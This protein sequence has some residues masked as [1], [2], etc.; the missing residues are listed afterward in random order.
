MVDFYKQLDQ[1]ANVIDYDLL[2][3]EAGV[4]TVEASYASQV[5]GAL[6]KGGMRLSGA[7]LELPKH[8]ASLA[9]M[10]GD[11]SPEVIE[12]RRLEIEKRKKIELGYKPFAERHL[13]IIK[14]HKQGMES[15]IRSHPEWEYEPPK[16]FLDLLTS[17]R[18]LSLAIAESTPVLVGAGI[19]VVGGRPDIGAVMMYASEGQESYDQ[20]IADGAT[21]EEAEQ[22]YH[23]YGSVATILESLRLKGMIKIG[24]ESYQAVLNQTVKKVAK[25]G[26]RGLTKEIIK[27][28][29]RESMEEIS[30]GAWQEFTAKII[31]GKDIPGGIWDF[32]DR[33][34]QEGL[35]GGTMGLIPG[36]GGAT[37]AQSRN[38]IQGTSGQA[39]IT[40]VE[41]TEIIAKASQQVD[42]N[43]S[44]E[45]QQEYL[46][47]TILDEIEKVRIQKISLE[48]VTNQASL[49]R[50]GNAIGKFLGIEET[51]EWIYST[52][53]VKQQMGV[54]K[55]N[56]ITIYGK[57]PYHQGING[58]KELKNTIIEEIGHV[59]KKPYR[60]EITEFPPNAKI[61]KSD[62]F[63]DSYE[64]KIGKNVWHF[65]A[66]DKAKAKQKWIDWKNTYGRRKI[67]HP[68]LRQWIS[69][70]ME[71]LFAKQE[72]RLA[73]K[74]MV[75]EKPAE[76][77]K[78]PKPLTRKQLLAAGHFIPE[79]LGWSDEQRRD[80]IE[81]LTGQRSLKGLKMA[82]LRAV[83]ELLQ[84][85]RG[86]AG[87]EM[88]ETDYG[89]P[90]QIGDRTTTMTSIMTEAAEDVADLPARIET[91]K[92]ITKKI[93]KE[94]QTGIWKRL[95]EILWGK[96]NSSKYH[97]ANLL[98]KTFSDICDINVERGRRIE[99]GHIRSVFNALLQAR[100][101]AEISDA[102]LAMLSKHLNPR[103]KILQ[104]ITEGVGTEIQTI[105]INDKRYDM[106][107]GE[108][109]DHYLITNQEDGLRHVLAGGLIVNNV[110]TGA[111]SQEK[112]DQLRFMIENNPKAK[113]LC[114]TF[115][116]I[117]ENIW[118][119]SINNVS[120]RLEGRDIAKVPDWWGL[121]VAYPR[122]L[123]GKEE[124][125]N[126][127][128][129]ENRSI[130][131][132][133]T[134]STR[135]L[136]IRDAF[137][138][139]AI[140]E[141][142]IAEY[143]GHAE[144][145]RIARTLI[146]NPDINNALDQK[147]YSDIRKKLLTIMERAQSLPR[148]EGAFGKFMAER[149]PGLY[150]AYLHFN[151]RVIVSQYTS[152]TNYGAF[153]S[154]KYMTH[155]LDGMNPD[156][157]RE[158][159]EMSDIAYD[160]FYMAH[161]S[162]ALGEMAKSD[163]VL[164]L[165]TH[166]AADINKL[167]ITLR[168]ADMGA[169]ASGLQIA[170]AEYLDAQNEKIVGDSAIWW[171]DKNVSFEEGSED[172]RR[173]ITKR[174]EWLWQ[175]SQPSW[176]KWNR[177]MM[178]SGLVR[179][180]FFPFRTFHEKSLTILHEANLEYERSNKSPHDRGRQ[181]KKYGAVLASY[182][183]NTIIRA[184]ILGLLAR[185]VKEPWQYVSDIL[186]APMSMFPIL[187][188]I[189]KNSIGNFINI[190]IGEKL[191]Y[192]G[193]AIEAFPTRVINIVAQAPADF[194]IAAAH[195]LKG[196]KDKART[197]FQR[198]VIKIY[199]GVGTAEGVPVSEINRVY[200]G[201]IKEE[202]KPIRRGRGARSRAGKPRKR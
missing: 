92:H 8:V 84:E 193:E 136:V 138:R 50:V 65:P 105:D 133:R 4:P 196:D 67:H 35:I 128:L 54:V 42:L 3:Q 113:I 90:I 135:P 63:P 123:P 145:T 141:N 23:L 71:Q 79:K 95:K 81:D 149:L 139:F 58:Q 15:I 146:N 44:S 194:S 199:K 7:L 38:L 117:G 55:G 119:L 14:Q 180:V 173:S 163:S 161:S 188:T 2:D 102:D 184:T 75:K 115:L 72:E 51:F 137:N 39:G 190:L 43:A 78:K 122:R 87:I 202:E 70:S 181:A 186:E 153:V 129:I 20:A 189:L 68:E 36:I 64:V 1:E 73:R 162:L 169:L 187:G 130:F 96:E 16:N 74:K 57:H 13:E 45:K 197:A 134:R 148:E 98:G 48:D 88:D 127:N 147:G 11:V 99:V 166:K 12:A 83:V 110:E 126:V 111:L 61:N 120:T 24:K 18:K 155:I 5:L 86:V 167:G 183:L 53:P 107:W 152:V 37:L 40:E 118:K 201:W 41:A 178:T 59:V 29:A 171:A 125:F 76:I 200:E 157:I 52:R 144:S 174:A 182:T 9:M 103:F 28:A 114:D 19:M 177:S 192:H 151:P 109:M 80:F 82:D 106:T 85:E 160:R 165:F 30:Q 159:L 46:T 168:L 131:K 195:Y 25:K 69:D 124:K 142:G 132:D 101:D 108:L 60:P 140:F 121:E 179:K 6:I 116:E 10:I 112:I 22:T 143:V 175:R 158:T 164:R 91:P 89:M 100:Q 104:K 66:K 94:R 49:E 170:K 150:R 34:A 185:K 56:K 191:E 97:L 47:E 26:F 27:E 154:T 172:W 62:V 176:D 77:V 93:A 32:I 198:A 33:R 21:P 31:Y 17:P 156:N